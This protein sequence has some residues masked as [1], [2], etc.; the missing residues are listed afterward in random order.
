MVTWVLAEEP[1]EDVQRAIEILEAR[2]GTETDPM[3]VC[4][5]PAVE[6]L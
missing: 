5:G 3:W 6:T 1:N 4:P 2:L